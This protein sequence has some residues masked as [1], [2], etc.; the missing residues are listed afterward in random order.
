M[1]QSEDQ[2]GHEHSYQREQQEVAVG[3][4]ENLRACV[5]A[6]V[7]DVRQ[8]E[9]AEIEA[10]AGRTMGQRNRFLPVMKSQSKS[11]EVANSHLDIKE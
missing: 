5:R 8:A 7:S 6:V 3:K 1:D 10:E 2:T 9:A 4:V 11:R